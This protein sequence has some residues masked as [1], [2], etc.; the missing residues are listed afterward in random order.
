VWL[1][2][3]ILGSLAL[4]LAVA[5][6]IIHHFFLAVPVVADKTAQESEAQATKPR[7]SFFGSSSFTKGPPLG[8]SMEEM[9]E[10]GISQASRAQFEG[11]VSENLRDK[12]RLF[13][14]AKYEGG[15]KEA[16]TRHREFV[17]MREMR[18]NPPAMALREAV[19]SAQY[20]ENLGLMKL[21]S[22]VTDETN[23]RG[24][25]KTNIESMIYAYQNLTEIYLKRNMK[26]KAQEAYLAYLRLMKE[27]AP[28]EQ[29]QGFDQ[30]IGEVGAAIPATASG[31]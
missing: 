13:A 31:N 23:R 1:N 8:I 24:I 27:K 2:P 18:N 16:E 6:V 12:R 5:G 15:R 20:S 14:V 17:A 26:S 19:E 25:D 9:E 29:G 10:L 22:F 30:A 11:A 4:T 28:A 7:F 21:E 3:Y